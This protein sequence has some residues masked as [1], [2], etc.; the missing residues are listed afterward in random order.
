MFKFKAANLRVI[1]TRVGK[2]SKLSVNLASVMDET[3]SVRIHVMWRN[4]K[5]EC[6]P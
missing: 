4:L 6:V 1:G 2:G 5:L 3:S